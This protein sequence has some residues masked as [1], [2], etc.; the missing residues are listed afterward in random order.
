MLNRTW[1]FSGKHTVA[2][3][4]TVIASIDAIIEVVGGDVRGVEGVPC[5][6]AIIEAVVFEVIAIAVSPAAPV[7]TKDKGRM[8]ASIEWIVVPALRDCFSF[9]SD[10]DGFTLLLAFL[11]GG[12]V[13]GIGNVVEF[14]LVHTVDDFNGG[15]LDVGSGACEGQ[16]NGKGSVDHNGG[17]AHDDNEMN[18]GD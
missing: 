11:A 1:N 12:P 7:R 16:A 13:A 4:V 18:G 6:V 15:G 9:V 17:E 8:T 3:T 10:Y 5:P 2:V 14:W